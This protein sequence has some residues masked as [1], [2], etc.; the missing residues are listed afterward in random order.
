MAETCLVIKH[1]LGV[2]CHK[3]AVG[4]GQ[5]IDLNKTGIM[6]AK[7]SVHLAEQSAKSRDVDEL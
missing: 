1:H 2:Q 5:G 7:K 4:F 6:R 3:A